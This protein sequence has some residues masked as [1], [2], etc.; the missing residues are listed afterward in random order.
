[1]KQKCYS[2]LKDF[3]LQKTQWEGNL[4]PTNASW[5]CLEQ[6]YQMD[7]EHRELGLNASC[8]LLAVW[9]WTFSCNNETW[10]LELL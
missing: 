2:L 3:R 6:A 5:S 9:L 1:M 8:S 4:G 10:L 7:R